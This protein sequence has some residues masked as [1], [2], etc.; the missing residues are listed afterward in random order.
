MV[1]IF[2]HFLAKPFLNVVCTKGVQK[3]KKARLIAKN[4]DAVHTY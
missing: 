1:A 4:I 3:L 2:K